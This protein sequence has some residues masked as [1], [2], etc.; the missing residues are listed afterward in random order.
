ME[1]IQNALKVQ[2]VFKNF[3]FSLKVNSV[4]RSHG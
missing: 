3:P 2:C 1:G 4:W